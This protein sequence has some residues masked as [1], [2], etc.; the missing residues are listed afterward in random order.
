MKVALQDL[1]AELEQDVSLY[2]PDQLR[3]R[4]EALDRIETCLFHKPRPEDDAAMAEESALKRRVEV[5]SELMDAANHALYEEIRA[6]IRRGDGARHL[7]EWAKLYDPAVHADYQ[8]NGVGYDYL[9]ALVTGV[10]KFD[11]PDSGIAELAPEMVFYQP[12]PA[13]FIFDLIQCSALN[14]QDVLIDL[15]SGLGHVPLVANICTGARCIGIEIEGLYADCARRSAQAL[16][17]KQVTFI[18][19]DVRLADLSEGT[20]FYLYT[21]F[22]GAVLRTVLDML[23]AEASKREIRVCSLGPCTDAVLQESWLKVEGEQIVDQLTL[24]RS[25]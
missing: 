3:Q 19:Q 9:D 22:K 8:L 1:V 16:A 6:E 17:L 11:E 21:P 25:V 2:E 13:R 5:I 18:Q 24:F 12:T 23:K 4:I 20:V 10:L 7:L 14:E 15:G